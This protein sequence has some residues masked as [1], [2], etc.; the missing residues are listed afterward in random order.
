M[1]HSSCSSIVH[2]GGKRR[3]V[4]LGGIPPLQRQ[5]ICSGT[6]TSAV[7]PA[8]RSAPSWIRYWYAST[9]ART[10]HLIERSR[11]RRRASRSRARNQATAALTALGVEVLTDARA[12]GIDEGV[13]SFPAEASPRA[14]CSGRRASW[15][16][17][18]QRPQI[19]LALLRQGLRPT[20]CRRRDR[21]HSCGQRRRNLV[22]I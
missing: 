22:G 10:G 7:S 15:P 12:Q 20:C 8:R 5:P 19:E 1:K 13:S 4:I 16:P 18:H 6:A 3:G 14:T 9:R 11:C 17:P 2:G 21:R